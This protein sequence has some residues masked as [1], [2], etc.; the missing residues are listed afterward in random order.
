MR[1]VIRLHLRVIAVFGCPVWRGHDA[2]IQGKAVQLLILGLDLGC[3]FPDT[4]EI[5]EVTRNVDKLPVGYDGL[6][7]VHRI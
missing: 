3:G 1:E 7:L 4:L 5:L 6:Q 2:C